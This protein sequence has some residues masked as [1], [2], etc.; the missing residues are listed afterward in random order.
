M[1]KQTVTPIVPD[2]VDRQTRIDRALS[3]DAERPGKP[4]KWRDR[5]QRTVDE[6]AEAL[7]VIDEQ[8][9][10]TNLMLHRTQGARSGKIS[11]RFL[12][13]QR[14]DRGETDR[15]RVPTVVLWHGRKGQ[16]ATRYRIIPRSERYVRLRRKGVNDEATKQL[17]RL[18]QELMEQRAKIEACY[19]PL[20][21]ASTQLQGSTIRMIRRM[22][23]ALDDIKA[24]LIDRDYSKVDDD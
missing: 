10:D 15:D 21:A 12:C 13:L 17:L 19:A 11:V 2:S 14:F 24:G 16:P 23:H 4:E 22:E 1:S 7:V 9:A 20:A 6:L 5:F 8:I 3:V 18:L